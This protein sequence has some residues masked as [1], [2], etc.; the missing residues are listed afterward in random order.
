MLCSEDDEAEVPA[1]HRPP[2]SSM[3]FLVAAVSLA[4]LEFR[5]DVDPRFKVLVTHSTECMGGLLTWLV[6]EQILTFADM[7]AAS[8]AHAQGKGLAPLDLNVGDFVHSLK[9]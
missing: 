7:A 4:A 1:K 3:D 8:F 5:A 6:A 2:S 9:R